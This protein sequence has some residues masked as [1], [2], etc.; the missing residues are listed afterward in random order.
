DDRIGVAAGAVLAAGRGGLVRA[1]RIERIHAVRLAVA[2]APAAGR[3]LEHAHVPEGRL[4][5]VERRV[6]PQRAERRRAAPGGRARARLDGRAV[7]APSA[8]ETDDR[9]RPARGIRLAAAQRL[10][11]RVARVLFGPR[12]RE[13]T[14]VVFDLA[15]ELVRARGRRMRALKA[16]LFGVSRRAEV[17]IGGADEAEPERVHAE[18]LRAT[19]RETRLQDVADERALGEFRAERR[20]RSWEGKERAVRSQL[21]VAQLVRRA[22]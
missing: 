4:S 13:T 2:R 11:D 3:I 19:E 12:D 21:E 10:E 1:V 16:R 9:P 8:E 5:G 6:G 7:V 15:E 22:E 20:F 18:R 14:G 17:R